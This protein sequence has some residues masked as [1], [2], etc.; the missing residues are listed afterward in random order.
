MGDI[1]DTDLKIPDEICSANQSKTN[2]MKKFIFLLAVAV[3][4]GLTAQNTLTVDNN[5]NSGAMYTSLQA[6]I[7]AAAIGDTIYIHPS[8]TSYGNVDIKKT[9][10]FRSIGHA[11]HY[12]NGL[13]A[14]IG[15]MDF[16][17]VIGAPGSTFSGIVFGRLSTSGSQNYSN[18][19][20]TNCRF[21]KVDC[22]STAGQCNDWLIAGNVIV[23]QNFGN[24]DNYNSEGWVVVN[25]HIRQ[26]EGSA[27]WSIFRRLGNGDVVRNNIV[28]TN[29]GQST[30]SKVFE[31]CHNL[32]V[33]NNLFLFTNNGTGISTAGNSITFNNNL[34]YSYPGLTL[35]TLNGNGNLDNQQ[36][37]FVNMGGDPSYSVNKNFH[38]ADGS[39]GEDAGSDGQDM[40]LYGGTYPFNTRGYPTGMPYPTSIEITNSVIGVGGTLNV[41]FEAVAN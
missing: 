37:V 3:P 14:T 30:A 4:L 39:P 17:A 23:A 28:V 40:G 9:L 8:P 27:S 13:V 34:T 29:Q 25:N 19:E 7:D 26:P 20:I 11:P 38:L 33:E 35:T 22:G 12:A 6:A 31:D 1:L 10:H 36:P 15:N 18:V 16:D 41:L 32:S 5:P 21:A 2:V 24:I